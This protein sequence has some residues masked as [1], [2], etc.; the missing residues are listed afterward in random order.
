[1]ASLVCITLVKNPASCQQAHIPF[2]TTILVCKHNNVCTSPAHRSSI[3]RLAPF[4]N[5]LKILV[6]KTNNKK[7]LHQSIP[8]IT[9]TESSY[10]DPHCLHSRPLG[11]VHDHPTHLHDLS[12]LHQAK[13]VVCEGFPPP[14]PF[15]PGGGSPHS[16]PGGA[17]W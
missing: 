13:V 14:G 2:H 17:P 4:K 6:L 12:A 8:T 7:K 10:V 1:M 11:L 16:F 5:K 15:Q 3:Y 9:P